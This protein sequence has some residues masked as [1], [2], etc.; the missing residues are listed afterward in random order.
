MSLDTAGVSLLSVYEGY[1]VQTGAGRL[2][3]R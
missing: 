3:G 2:S 1:S